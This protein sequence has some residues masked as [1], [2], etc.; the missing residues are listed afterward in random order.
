MVH[1]APVLLLNGEARTPCDGKFHRLGKMPMSGQLIKAVYVFCNLVTP[2]DKGADIIMWSP[3]YGKAYPPPYA[4]GP[5]SQWASIADLH[6]FSRPAGHTGGRQGE[7]WRSYS[8]DGILIR[9]YIEVIAIGWGGGT[10]EIY[11]T[12]YVGQS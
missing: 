5:S 12:V 3:S 6:I 11:S 4:G 2:G 7:S 1:L 10:M 8:P 9:D